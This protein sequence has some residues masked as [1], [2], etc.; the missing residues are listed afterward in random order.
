MIRLRP[1]I[2]RQAS[3]EL[4]DFVLAALGEERFADEVYAALDEYVRIGAAEWAQRPGTR[5]CAGPFVAD[6][7]PDSWPATLRVAAERTLTSRSERGRFLTWLLW[8]RPSSTGRPP[9]GLR[10]L[11]ESGGKTSE[12]SVRLARRLAGSRCSAFEVVE[13]Q[14][15]STLRVRDLITDRE[16]LFD[17][18]DLARDAQRWDIFMARLV[19]FE[20]DRWLHCMGPVLP[21]QAGSILTSCLD[22]LAGTKPGQ[23]DRRSRQARALKRRP[24]QMLR[25]CREALETCA[26]PPPLTNL[27][28]ER[29]V[30]SRLRFQLKDRGRALAALERCPF[31]DPVPGAEDGEPRFVWLR[32]GCRPRRDD[33]AVR[34]V[35]GTVHLRGQELIVDC[36]SWERGKAFQASMERVTDGAGRHL[37][38][39]HTEFEQTLMARVRTPGHHDWPLDSLDDPRS[40]YRAVWNAYLQWLDTPIG[41][42]PTLGGLTPR[43]A[44]LSGEGRERIAF[45]LNCLD[46]IQLRA[47]EEGVPVF[48]D[49]N[50]IRSVL[51]APSAEI[52]Y[53]ASVGE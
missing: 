46:D 17:E 31:L 27:D 42:F 50:V 40:S 7:L 5:S 48:F 26:E 2:H 51:D 47:G 16:Y 15:Q 53:A 52:T 29:I 12:L 24:L 21:P 37:L 22:N 11:R 41:P 30:P 45:Y 8:D 9:V 13:H 18:V 38:T 34:I 35:L 32:E 23:P 33:A 1:A 6:D 44:V 39:V 20:G 25:C 3:A 19:E 4:G 43:Q 14:S 49:L 36:N 10:I 28:G